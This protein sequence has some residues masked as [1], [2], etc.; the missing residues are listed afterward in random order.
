MKWSNHII[1]LLLP[2]L[3]VAAQNSTKP[4][5]D[6][7]G[8]YWI[9]SGSLK[10]GFV[11]YGAA[12]SDLYINDKY[13]VQRDLIAGWENASYYGIDGQHP[14]YGNVPGRYAN[15]IKNSTFEIDG[16]T[17]HITPNE[18]PTEEHPDG[19]NSLH[20][21]KDGWG[22]RNFT[23]VA[24]TDT[25][26]T[27]SIVDPDGKEGFPGEVISYVTY[28]LE[29]FD[30]HIS[31]VAVPTTKATPIMLS[32][33]TYW[34]LD[35]FANNETQS[36][37]NHTLHLPYSGQRVAVDNILIPTGEIQA[38]AKGSVNDFWSA[39]K[40]LGASFSDPEIV[41]NCGLNCTG[42]D[43][44]WTVNRQSLGNYD[45]RTHSPV[46]T[47][48]SAWSGIK[49][50]IYTDQDAFQ[51]YSCNGQNG[52]LTLKES[53]G[54]TDNADFPRTIPKYGCVVLEVQDYIDGINHPEWH[55]EPKQIFRPGGDPY[56]LQARYHFSVGEEKD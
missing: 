33:H 53:Q 37:L 20:G 1:G 50:D 16:E 22:W 34:N 28:T 40:Q 39:P 38:N 43:N 30:W 31:M 3:G 7:N 25:S 6:K 12:I 5:A 24:H 14:N 29:G 13:G 27:F 41:N 21:G 9:S 4:V 46:A 18:H 26:I 51:V 35:G 10:A 48:S 8:K 54:L 36:A 23:V 17:Y 32:S 11:P 19:I 44:C 52:T 42:Y 45:W 55:R 47:I 49:L 15:R 2:A 56:V